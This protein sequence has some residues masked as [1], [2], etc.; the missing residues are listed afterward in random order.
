[1]VFVAVAIIGAAAVLLYL[2]GREASLNIRS[3]P[4]GANALMD[5]AEV[6][7]TPLVLTRVAP[8][9]HTIE[10]RLSG[11]QTWTGTAT[12]VRGTTTQV[13]AN[14]THAAYSLV[15][16]STPAGA[17]VTLDG[18]AKGVTPLT[19]TG[20]K[21]RNYDM[22]VSLNGYA[23]ITRS[24]DLSD[25]TQTTQDFSLVQAFGKLTITSDPSG[26]QVIVGGTAYGTTPLN[27]DSFPVGTYNLTLKLDGSSDVVDTISIANGATFSKQYKFI[28]LVG[29]LSVSTDPAGAS[30]TID[31][32]PT[33]QIAPFT[34]TGL[35]QGTH[36]VLLE[37]DG[38][39]PW[40]GEVTISQ[41]QTSRL[42][43]A[44]TKLQ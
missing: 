33:N 16:T 24:V 17:T 8:G 25:D 37:L 26:A 27:V 23:P 39:L 19:L 28:S 40:S 3:F 5:G 14:M 31:G 38:Y 13:I 7:T 36:D 34:L 29:G 2:Q 4:S 21:P 11:W 22:V 9:T 35:K 18:T 43:I 6:G 15:V 41:G 44:L 1:M 32:Q 42:S 12:A 30:I 10:L 20:L